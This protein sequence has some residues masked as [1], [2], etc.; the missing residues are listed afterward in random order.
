MC[1]YSFENAHK[2]KN[3][4]KNVQAESCFECFLLNWFDIKLDLNNLYKE[5]IMVILLRP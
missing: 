5:S 3:L 2:L 4:L 1:A